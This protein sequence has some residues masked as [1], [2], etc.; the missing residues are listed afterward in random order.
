MANAT[1]KAARAVHGTN[2]QNLLE[3]IVRQKIYD[4]P[5]WKNECFALTAET[6][7]ER[8]VELRCVGGTTGGTRKAS[9]FLCLTLK[10]LQIQPEAEIV[11]EYIRNEEFKYLRL[12]G[13]FYLRLTGRPA[14]VFQYLEP[15]LN[16]YRRV[17][18]ANPDGSFSLDHVDAVVHRLLT[19][20]YAFDVALPRLPGRPTLEAGGFLE[21]WQSP[22][23]EDYL[24]AEERRR[25]ERAAA[26]EAAAQAAAAE[27]AEAATAGGGGGGG[28]TVRYLPSAMERRNLAGALAG[29]TPPEGEKKRKAGRGGG[30]G[31]KRQKSGDVGGG[32]GR[33]AA[34]G[35]AG[36]GD[37]GGQDREIA[38]ANAL[39]LKL[40][41]KPLRP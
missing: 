26:R 38:E 9:R 37:G 25:A 7:V 20:P 19:R 6:L 30:E 41:L 28:D 34:G 22:I 11:L 14:E 8:A 10:L 5:Y 36:T 35:G 32:A 17:R 4:L 21:P 18:V 12:L 15:L 39:R 24:E 31:G 3:N 16:D 2:P 33:E 13:A 1:D 29:P 23:L 40:G 27:A